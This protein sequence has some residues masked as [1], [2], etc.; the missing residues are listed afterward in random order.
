MRY[1]LIIAVP[2]FAALAGLVANAVD[3]RA[4]VEQ[5]PPSMAAGQTVTSDKPYHSGTSFNIKD[6]YGDYTYTLSPKRQTLHL[7]QAASVPNRRGQEGGSLAMLHYLD[8]KST[9]KF[10][11]Q[12]KNSSHCPASFFNRYAKQKMLFASTPSLQKEIKSWENGHWKDT[13]KWQKLQLSGRCI[14]GTE[15]FIRKGEDV[16]DRV[17]ARNFRGC[18]M[19]YVESLVSRQPYDDQ[20]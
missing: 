8:E 10:E 2:V 18:K 12:F 6:K 13:S 7:T 11:Q 15:R 16:T 4:A 14:T 3:N 1:K 20:S 17:N 19:F 9:L 5:A